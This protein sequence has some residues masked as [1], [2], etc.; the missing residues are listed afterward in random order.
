MIENRLPKKQK[1]LNAESAQGLISIQEVTALCDR[2]QVSHLIKAPVRIG[3][4]AGAVN[5]TQP[6]PY[7]TR[8]PIIGVSAVNLKEFHSD[9]PFLPDRM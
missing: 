2:H 3:V 7:R 8:K 5:P 4:L 1:A 6:K 9:L